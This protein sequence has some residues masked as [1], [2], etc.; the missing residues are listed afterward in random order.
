MAAMLKTIFCGLT[1]LCP[2]VIGASSSSSSNGNSPTATKT[3]T[4]RPYGT[5]P[6][7]ADV[8]QNI[9]PNILD[10]KAVNPQSVCPGYKASDIKRNDY[11]LTG[12]L[13]LAGSKCNV[14]G[15]DIE[16]LQLSVQYQSSDRVNVQIWPTYIGSKN[17]SWF[18]PPASIMRAATLDSNAAHT[19][20]LNDLEFSYGNEP[21]FWMKMIR[22]SNSDVLFDTSN[23]KLVFENQFVEFVTALPEDYNLYGLGESIH[24]LRLGNNFTKTMWNTDV[25]DPIDYNVYGTHPIY[26]DTRYYKTG[27]NGSATYV[28]TSE[29]SDA[30]IYSSMTHAVYYRNA[31]AHEILLRPEGLTWRTLGGNI[32]L[33]FYSGTL[34]IFQNGEG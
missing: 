21:S 1:A 27:S 4:S 19:V 13:T 17:E 29:A 20:P 24:A 15:D 9:L 25:G 3:A 23:K 28:P 33:Y 18:V 8:G 7:D 22:K 6:P 34:T 14:Y 30:G 10:P 12:T 11:G 2:V 26:Y 5:L 16:S 31:H 32:D